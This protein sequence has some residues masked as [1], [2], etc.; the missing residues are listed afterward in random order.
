MIAMT[1]FIDLFSLP[2]DR[3]ADQADATKRRPQWT[4]LLRRRRAIVN[5]G[6][7]QVEEKRG[8]RR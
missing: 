4:M 8:N 7:C 3:A 2:P 5:Q 6:A 1:I